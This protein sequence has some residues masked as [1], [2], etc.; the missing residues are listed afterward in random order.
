MFIHDLAEGLTAAGFLTFTT[1][2]LANVSEPHPP[3]IVLRPA[4]YRQVRG[5][6]KAVIDVDA[7][8]AITAQ[9]GADQIVDAFSVQVWDALLNLTPSALPLEAGRA[10][11]F[12]HPNT[13]EQWLVCTLTIEEA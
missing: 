7:A 10:W 13:G 11:P 6:R 8:G 1:E 2:T 4:G 12:D 9:R 3:C 5:G